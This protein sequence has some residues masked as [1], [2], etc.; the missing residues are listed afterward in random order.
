[1]PT[2][3]LIVGITG[4]DGA[5]LARF[6]LDKGYDV[7]GTSRN[8][9][10]ARTDSLRAL[11]IHDKV[12]LSSVSPVDFRSVSDAIERVAPHEIYNLSGQSSVA[13]SFSR[14]AET[15]SSIIQATVNLLEVLRLK[16]S[17]IRFYNAGSSEVFGDTGGRAANEGTA[18]HPKSP[19]GVAKAAAVSLVANYRDGYGLFACSGLLFNHESP[20]R[21]D[22]FVTRK[23]TAAAARIANG[24]GE[25]LQLGDISIHRDWG[26]A[27][28]Y[29]EAMWMMLQH[30]RPEDFVIASGVAHR[31]DEF[32]AAA[33]AEVGLAWQDHVE[34]DDLMKRTNDIRYSRGDASKAARQLGWR[35]KIGF[36]EIISRMV[37]AEQE[38]RNQFAVNSVRT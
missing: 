36:A 4:Q 15:L 30:D 35:P 10:L 13:L 3:A 2:I 29:V 31:L 7:Y 8:I 6:L 23:I 5:Y 33:F 9:E 34:Y 32:V 1:V 37:R 28:D 12:S 26:W 14:P 20:L 24:S 16:K 18:Y 27:P 21:P 25:R 11:G 17:G 38:K 19:Y 22:H